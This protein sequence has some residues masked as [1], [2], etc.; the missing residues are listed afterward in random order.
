M[1]SEDVTGGPNY[2]FDSDPHADLNYREILS[3][4]TVV[5][6][7]SREHNY[8][9]DSV[10]D[11][12]DTIV[13]TDDGRSTARNRGIREADTDWI[14]VADD[15]ITFPTTLTAI[16]LDG[17]HEF[18]VIGLEDAWPMHWALTRYMMFHRDLWQRVGGFDELR[19][20][21]EDTDFCIRAE[22]AGAT[23]CTIPRR[24]V[25]HHD[26]ESEF[27]TVEHLEWLWFLLRQHPVHIFPMVIK[28]GLTK[29]NLLSPPPEYDAGWG[30]RAWAFHDPQEVNRS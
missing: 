11:W 25:P 1:K 26:Q 12:I 14:V 23:V 29:V 19:E 18:H 15:D 28:L 3:N 4:V 7:T 8:T 9:A 20:H 17:M 2:P 13:R 22:K 16:L 30:G 27:E 5:I 6:P 10:P 21:G 24:V